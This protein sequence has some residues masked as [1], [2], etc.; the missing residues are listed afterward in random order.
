MIH[1]TIVLTHTTPFN[2][3]EEAITD[4]K[5]IQNDDLIVFFK[6]VTSDGAVRVWEWDENQKM[7]VTTIWLANEMYQQYMSLETQRN[8]VM[9]RLVANGWT[10]VNIEAVEV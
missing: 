4:Y 9:T 8:D 3:I 5:S 1:Q 2:N 10:F 6:T 7:T